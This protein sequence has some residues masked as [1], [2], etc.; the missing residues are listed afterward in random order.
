[1][2]RMVVTGFRALSVFAL[3]S[4]CTAIT[5]SRSASITTKPAPGPI[6]EQVGTLEREGKLEISR[7]SD[8]VGFLVK[9]HTCKKIKDS[10]SNVQ[11][12][13]TF[14]MIGNKDEN[15][16]F[17]AQNL[18]IILANGKSYPG[19]TVSI[20]DSSFAEEVSNIF[21]VEIPVSFK[22]NF[23]LPDDTTL[24][25]YLDVQKSNT[26]RFKQIAIENK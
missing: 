18:S 22:V 17:R 19:T 14:G 3:I 9:L 15:F 26:V 20:I 16:S 5:A 21:R 25:Y 1:M 23:K 2:N 13:F 12:D 11:C 4:N 6:R 24:L 8:V 7:F 10:A